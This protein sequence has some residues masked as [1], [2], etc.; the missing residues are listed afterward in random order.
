[1]THSALCIYHTIHHLLHLCH[2]YFR[3]L[4]EIH[5]GTFLQ[6]TKD[7]GFEYFEHSNQSTHT[8]K[9][10]FCCHRFFCMKYTYAT[11]FPKTLRT[12]QTHG[13][14]KSDINKVHNLKCR[15]CQGAVSHIIS[16]YFQYISCL[17]SPTAASDFHHSAHLK[18]TVHVFCRLYTLQ[19]K[20]VIMERNI[21]LC[22]CQNVLHS[23]K[24]ICI[25]TLSRRN[26]YKVV[27][28]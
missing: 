18:C 21:K 12:F 13:C 26:T 8:T 4:Y 16:K 6:L 14:H 10:P 15:N 27:A 2:T 17:T 3:V 24:R 7:N 5:S 9:N 11:N 28:K 1:M 25:L 20:A 22:V 19:C 23:I